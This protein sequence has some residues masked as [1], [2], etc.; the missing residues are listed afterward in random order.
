MLPLLHFPPAQAYVLRVA[1]DH[2]PD[3]ATLRRWERDFRPGNLCCF[4]VG[5]DFPAPQG[6]GECCGCGTSGW[7]TGCMNY[8]AGGPY[9]SGPWSSWC[10]GCEARGIGEAWERIGELTRGPS[11]RG[12]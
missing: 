3:A 7:W 5:P 2:A 4:A 6:W 10:D 8:R 1:A 9:G 11:R 12:G